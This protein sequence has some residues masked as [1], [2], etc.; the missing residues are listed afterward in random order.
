MEP[1]ELVY[2]HIAMNYEIYETTRSFLNANGVETP[3]TSEY[4]R[5]IVGRLTCI[6]CNM[7]ECENESSLAT[8]QF[9]ATKQRY[10]LICILP[11]MIHMFDLLP[12]SAFE[13]CCECNKWS[14]T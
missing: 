10:F 12:V 14:V 5:L 9:K 6:I 3:E 7:R 13:C 8:E 11:M 1:R 2:S 4:G